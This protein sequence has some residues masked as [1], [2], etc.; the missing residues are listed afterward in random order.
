MLIYIIVVTIY[1]LHVYYKPQIDTIKFIF[2]KERNLEAGSVT[3]VL[4]Y[5]PHRH[6]ALSL[7]K[8]T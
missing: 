5:L 4:E 1:Y 3:Q 7:K 8:S 2:Q 6:E